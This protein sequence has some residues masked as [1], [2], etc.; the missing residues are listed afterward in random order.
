VPL[1][2]AGHWSDHVLA[3]ARGAGAGDGC[4]VVTT[5]LPVGLTCGAEHLSLGSGVWG[6][7]SLSLPEEWQ[8][9]EWEN[10]L[11]GERVRLQRELLVAEALRSFPV[12]LLAPPAST[13]SEP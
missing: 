13:S 3:F 6:D 1:P 7:T 5:R 12:A 11:T 4:L 8:G 9:A 2:A 10:R